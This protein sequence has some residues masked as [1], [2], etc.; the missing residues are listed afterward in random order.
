[1]HKESTFHFLKFKT[2]LRCIGDIY[3]VISRGASVCMEKRA[4]FSS[5]SNT[6]Y[7]D[8]IP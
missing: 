4:E 8:V 5:F 3:K 6:Y 1:M 7:V 2:G